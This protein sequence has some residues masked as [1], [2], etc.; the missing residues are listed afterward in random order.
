MPVLWGLQE[1]ALDRELGNLGA[2]TCTAVAAMREQGKM[3]ALPRCYFCK[4]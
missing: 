3:G 4:L 1:R 2:K